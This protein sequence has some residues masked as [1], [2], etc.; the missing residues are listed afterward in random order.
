M[1]FRKL[2]PNISLFGM[3]GINADEETADRTLSPFFIHFLIHNNSLNRSHRRD[4]RKKQVE[5]RYRFGVVGMP[6]E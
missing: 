4:Q 3:K 1:E 2:S 6:T 5:T